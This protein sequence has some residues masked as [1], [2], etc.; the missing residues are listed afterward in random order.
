MSQQQQQRPQSVQEQF[1]RFFGAP[2]A[3][4]KKG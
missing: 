2:A 1:D 4:A 3:P